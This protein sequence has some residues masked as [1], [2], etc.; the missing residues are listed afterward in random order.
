MSAKSIFIYDPS[1]ISGSTDL[2]RNNFGGFYVPEETTDGEE[3]N[4]QVNA[5]GQ[6]ERF[7]TSPIN[8][9]I[10]RVFVFGEGGGPTPAEDLETTDYTNLIPNYSFPV[11]VASNSENI[12]SD[13][14]WRAFIVGGEYGEKTYLTKISNTVHEFLKMETEQPYSKKEEAH[15]SDENL[16]SVITI[17]YDYSQQVFI[18]QN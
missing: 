3:L 1:L 11:R 16:S 17:S 12:N 14:E 10:E 18:N 9:E 5:N 13:Q 8:T 7:V 6:E 2:F 4:F 15:L